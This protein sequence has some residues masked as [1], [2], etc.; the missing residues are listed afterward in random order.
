MV[1][2]ILL[3]KTVR[4]A[5]AVTYQTQTCFPV[6]KSCSALALSFRQCYTAK[7]GHTRR[8]LSGASCDAER[9]GCEAWICSRE[10]RE[11][12]MIFREGL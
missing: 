9:T 4:S 12:M 5:A 2:W 6:S 3:L 7:M 11:L 1:A 10:R 8:I